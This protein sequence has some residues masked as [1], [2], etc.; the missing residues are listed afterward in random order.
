LFFGGFISR[1]R[2]PARFSG[3]VE[4]LERRDT[5]HLS[6]RLHDGYRKCSTHPSALASAGTCIRRP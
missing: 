4:W 3:A 5:D 6:G 2:I 1:L